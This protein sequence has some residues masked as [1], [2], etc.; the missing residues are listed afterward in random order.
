MAAEL[1]DRCMSGYYVACITTFQKMSQDSSTYYVTG[2][3]Q[4]L[5]NVVY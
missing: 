2:L 1:G 4:L 3:I 5:S